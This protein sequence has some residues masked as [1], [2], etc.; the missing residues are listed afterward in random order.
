M[1]PADNYRVVHRSRPNRSRRASF[2]QRS[3]SEP[4][5]STCALGMSAVW[6]ADYFSER[7]RTKPLGFHF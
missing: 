4:G 7:A 3:L 2:L 5:W 6:L 1:Y